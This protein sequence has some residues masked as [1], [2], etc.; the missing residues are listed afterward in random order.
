MPSYQT[1]DKLSLPA[2]AKK[3]KLIEGSKMCTL[4]GLLLYF[5]TTLTE[6]ES[7][8]KKDDERAY[9]IRVTFN[10]IIDNAL[11][12]KLNVSKSYIRLLNSVPTDYYNRLDGD[13]L[14]LE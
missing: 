2:L 14:L 3:L 8:L 6:L 10:K 4:P 11:C 7:V 12:S 13:N 1:L 9:M 5:R